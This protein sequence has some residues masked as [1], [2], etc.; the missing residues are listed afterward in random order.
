M[1]AAVTTGVTPPVKSMVE[2]SR[3]TELRADMMALASGAPR[4]T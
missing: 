3:F 2:A 4:G 1:S